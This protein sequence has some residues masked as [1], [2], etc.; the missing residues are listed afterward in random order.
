[1][2]KQAQ[3]QDGIRAEALADLSLTT[4]QAE[5]TKAGT[6][7]GEGKKVKIDFCKTDLGQ[8]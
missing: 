2:S 7:W 6:L 4:A 8:A 1:M 5:R 3:I